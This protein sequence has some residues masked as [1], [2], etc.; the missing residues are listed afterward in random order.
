MPNAP[1]ER[2]LD[3][4]LDSWDRNNT[5][6]LNLLRALPQG[7]L[8][9]RAMES[10]PSVAEQFTH[11]HFVRLVF[12]SEDA[13]E[14]ARELPEEEWAFERDPGRIAQMLN[15]SATV[16][17]EAIKSAVQAGRD[18]QVHYDHPVLL[19]QHMLWHEG[20]HHGQIKLALKLA[21]CPIT[22]QEAGPLTWG[23][24]MRKSG[25]G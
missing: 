2:L 19:L 14:S 22:D 7:G 18:M 11:I 23:V 16:V 6:L 10:S 25:A 9:V 3:A 15:E 8:E 13:P 5:I 1:E 21:G 20:Y 17:R 12:V 4:L 24:W